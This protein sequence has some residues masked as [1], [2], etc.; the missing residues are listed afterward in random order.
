MDDVSIRIFQLLSEKGISKSEFS[1]LSGI[2][3]ATL[4]H[5]ESGRNKA[6]LKL[7][8]ACLSVF[9][10]LDLN[11]LLKGDVNSSKQEELEE[12]KLTFPA[13][14]GKTITQPDLINTQVEPEEV[15]MIYSDNT[16]KVLKRRV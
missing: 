4:S 16:F 8:Q 13:D 6:S 12:S 10:D 2:S 1:Q 7:I 14:E 5:I 15:M 3:K 11:W 9:P